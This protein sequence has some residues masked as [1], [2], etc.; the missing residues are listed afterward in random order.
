MC[1]V[2]YDA[3]CSTRASRFIQYA[4][5]RAVAPTPLYHDFQDRFLR[6]IKRSPQAC[7]RFERVRPSILS[8]SLSCRL[9]RPYFITSS[10]ITSAV[11]HYPSSPTPSRGHSPSNSITRF[12]TYPRS[13]RISVPRRFTTGGGGGATGGGEGS[14]SVHDHPLVIRSWTRQLSKSIIALSIRGQRVDT[15]RCPPASQPLALKPA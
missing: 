7:V 4:G 1:T 5:T 2:E 14:V 3:L 11:L 12:T 13:L 9:I 8:N 10:I 15:R 6:T